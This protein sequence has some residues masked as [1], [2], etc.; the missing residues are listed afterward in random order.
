MITN[1]SYLEYPIVTATGR[2]QIL[3][4]VSFLLHG[5]RSQRAEYAK[6]TGF[7]GKTRLDAM[8]GEGLGE[9]RGCTTHA[10]KSKS[11]GTRRDT[12]MY[13][14]LA[15]AL[16]LALLIGANA[17]AADSPRITTPKTQFGFNLGDDYQLIN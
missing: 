2:D 16:A 10:L 14:A 13:H 4:N 17:P 5:D 12:A 1:S 8:R 3:E 7:P 11:K 6:T 9:G 15:L